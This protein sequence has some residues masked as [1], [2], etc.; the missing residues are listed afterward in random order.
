M[1]AGFVAG[2][3]FEE[4]RLSNNPVTIQPQLSGPTAMSFRITNSCGT[5][6]LG[7]EYGWVDCDV[8]LE[9]VAVAA[10]TITNA[11]VSDP[12][13]IDSRLEGDL[14]LPTVVA[15][16]ASV[17]LGFVIWIVGP[18]TGGTSAFLIITCG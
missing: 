12:D 6:Q 18:N 16:G 4:F 15:S 7:G 11:T 17:T 5:Q 3:W 14:S 9:N 10:H 8:T 2:V 13:A 1:L